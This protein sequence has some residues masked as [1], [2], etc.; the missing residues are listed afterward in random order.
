MKSSGACGVF[1]LTA[2][3]ASADFAQAAAEPEASEPTKS[4]FM[5]FLEQDYLFGTWGGKRTWL[6]DRGVDLEL[7]YFGTWPRNMSGGI[8]TGQVYEGALMTVLDLDS[9]KLAGYSGGHL[10][11]SGLWLHSG[12]AFSR[13]YV[14]DLN[15]VSLLDFPDSLRLWELWYE[16][17]FWENRISFK[18]G[19]M[20]I[21]Q[22]FIV[23][24]HYLS[25]ASLN[26]LNQTFF[27]PTVAFN[28]YDQNIPGFPIGHHALASTPYGAPGARLRVSPTE[29]CY[30]QAAVYDGNPDR[31]RSG[32]RIN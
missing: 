14:G 11:A 28:V 16:H 18:L 1:C 5:Q 10:R 13:N 32:T 27:F 24:E 21:D 29:R 22:D 15:Q 25:L 31:S 4:G 9:E 7:V 17:N 23:P 20:A 19:Q 26:F 8:K 30:V 2:M 12:D 3:L 6:Q